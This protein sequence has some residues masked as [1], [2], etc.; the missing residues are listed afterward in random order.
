MLSGLTFKPLIHF[1]F[2]LERTTYW[3]KERVH[4]DISNKGII[5][6]IYKEFI[7]INTKKSD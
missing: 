4:N 2:I 7:C 3:L 5:P 1:Y 6:K